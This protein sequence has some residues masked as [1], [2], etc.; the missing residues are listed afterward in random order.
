MS[1]QKKRY[2]KFIRPIS[3]LVH[4]VILN[5]VLYYFFRDKFELYHVAYINV[6]WLLISY[7]TK[8]YSLHRLLKAPKVIT[9]FL[10]QIIIFTLAYFAYINIF[11]INISILFHVKVLSIIYLAIALFRVSFLYALK[12]YRIGGGNYRKVV[13]IG[14]NENVK[15]II[16]FLNDRSEYGYRFIGYF[17]NTCS[18]QDNFLGKIDEA[19]E[20]ISNEGIH[21]LYCST[22]ELSQQQIKEFIDFA[23]N[24]LIIFKLIPDVKDVFSKEMVLEYFDYT[25]VLS[26][27]KLPFD[28]PIVKYFKRGFDIVF[29]LF[30]I[31]FLL[32]WL[33]PV[34]FV[35]IKLE[36][37]GPLF[38]KQE[39]DGLGG[40]VFYCYKFRSMRINQEANTMQV[41]KD[42]KRITKVGK[43]IRRTSIDELPQFFNV[44]LDDMSVVGPRPHMLVHTKKYA[45][46]I[47]KYM[48][49]HF[50]KPGITG[51]AQVRGY[52]GEIKNKI[53]MEN[54]IRLDIYYIENWS[55]FLDLKIIFQT[56]LNLFRT[57]EKAY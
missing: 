56:I 47:D 45:K 25:P 22:T 11:R 53:D 38:F 32:S 39:R 14:E 52:R 44:L 7:Y 21:E 8:F 18:N 30:I 19:F 37:K 34:M 31:I 57:E 10:S 42:D 54:R 41:C 43:F 51:L 3:V 9:R 23:D 29:A 33:I 20:F 15:S 48:V 28:K 36:S 49:R 46:E 2:S 26:L 50:V 24:N 1:L 13:V 17:S 12:K 55:F 40:H 4:L 6:G 27:R 5:G 16:K 35:I